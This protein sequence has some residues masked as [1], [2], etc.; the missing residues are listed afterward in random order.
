M[1]N[2]RRVE[3]LLFFKMPVRR[4]FQDGETGLLGHGDG[5]AA[6]K[7]RCAGGLHDLTLYRL[8][9]RLTGREWQIGSAG[10]MLESIAAKFAWQQGRSIKVQRHGRRSFDASSPLIEPETR[11]LVRTQSMMTRKR[12]GE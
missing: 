7:F 5:H 4:P 2:T 10:V 9:A 1:E 6:G 11:R 12:A 3:K 8:A